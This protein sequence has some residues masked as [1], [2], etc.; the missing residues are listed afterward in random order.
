MDFGN[1][2]T[3]TFNHFQDRRSRVLSGS[4]LGVDVQMLL[5]ENDKEVPSGERG[6]NRIRGTNV[7]KGYYKRPEATA[8]AFTERWFITA[9]SASWMRMDI[10]RSSTERK[11]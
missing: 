7:M 9:I 8:E 11:I 6:G 3:S 5:N 4:D 1:I 2:T 10:W